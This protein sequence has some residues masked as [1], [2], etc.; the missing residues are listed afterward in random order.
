MLSTHRV[1]KWQLAPGRAYRRA[2][3]KQDVFMD[4]TGTKLDVLMDVL[5]QITD[6]FTD[7]LVQI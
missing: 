3:T 2:G 7:V 1:F 6:V 5:V 4:V